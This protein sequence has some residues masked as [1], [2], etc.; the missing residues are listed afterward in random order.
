MADVEEIQYP[1]AE[2]DNVQVPPVE[3]AAGDVHRQGQPVIEDPAPAAVPSPLAAQD[4]Q[5][6]V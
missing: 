2:G 5:L 3:A 1:D 6:E 4:E